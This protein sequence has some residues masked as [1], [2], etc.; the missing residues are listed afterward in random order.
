MAKFPF[1]AQAGIHPAAIIEAKIVPQTTNIDPRS[2]RLPPLFRVCVVKAR[3]SSDA[4]QP[5]NKIVQIRRMLKLSPILYG[6]KECGLV[7]LTRE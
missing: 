6:F 3:R 4:G 2:R 1:G 5:H 7:L